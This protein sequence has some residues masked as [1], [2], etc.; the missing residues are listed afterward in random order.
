MADRKAV[1]TASRSSRPLL[2]RSWKAIRRNRSAS[3][4]TSYRIACALFF[5]GR[6]LGLLYG[7]QGAI[8]RLTST[9]SPVT[10][11]LTDGCRG[12]QILS[13]RLAIDFLG[14]L[15]MRTVSEV[16]GFG[17][18][19]TGIATASGRTGDGTRLECLHNLGNVCLT[20]GK[21]HFG[22]IYALHTD[23]LARSRAII[24]DAPKYRVRGHFRS[25]HT[26]QA[27]AIFRYGHDKQTRGARTEDRRSLRN[28]SVVRILRA[29]P[30][31]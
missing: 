10:F 2:R 6:L 1:S 25:G 8:F 13:N 3:R 4:T 11:R 21:G 15:K 17:A 24:P 16:I 12:Q 26:T 19:A 22:A 29:A 23:R 9:N 27:T 28:G 18:M 20:F 7:S 30:Y 14:Q 5:L 31:L